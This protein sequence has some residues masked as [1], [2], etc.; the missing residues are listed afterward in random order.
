MCFG[1][2]NKYLFNVLYSDPFEDLMIDS[3]KIELGKK[4]SEDTKSILDIM[5]FNFG[6][7]SYFAL[8]DILFSRHSPLSVI[9]SN[10]QI[11][12]SSMLTKT[13]VPKEYIRLW[14]EVEI[15]L[16]W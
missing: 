11:L 5:I 6:D 14:Y 7:L 2:Y 8:N 15:L 1:I 4:I 9:F 10:P 12:Y 16:N 13:K 3:K